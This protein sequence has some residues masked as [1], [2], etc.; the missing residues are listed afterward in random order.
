VTGVY[1]LACGIVFVVG[2]VALIRLFTAEEQVV[3]IGAIYLVFAAIYEISDALY[4]V[5]SGALRGA[6]D[7]FVPTVVMASLCWSMMVAGGYCMA[8]FVPQAGFGGPW[9]V[10]CVYGWI[11]GVYML[12]RFTGGKWRGIHLA[13]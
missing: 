3:R 1:I 6:G 7:T 12:R 11:L 5:Y 9:A 13:N 2:R 8:R 4:I 10:A